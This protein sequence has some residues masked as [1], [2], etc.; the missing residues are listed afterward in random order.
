[1]KLTVLTD[2]TARIDVYC[3]AEPAV[4]YAIEDGDTRVLFDTGYS[5][6]YLRNAR[7]LGLELS[8]VDAAVLSHGHNDHTGGLACFPETDKRPLLYAHPDVFA[9]RRAEGAAIGS[10][11]TREQA[12]ER[13]DLR[14]SR[15]PQRITERLTFLGEIPRRMAFEPPETVGE[16]FL[17]GAW[18]PDTVRDDSALVYRGRDGLCV[19]TGCSHAGICNILA[20]AQ[21]VCGEERIAC[22]VGGFHLLSDSPRVTST[23]DWLARRNIARLCPSHCT[24]FAARAA[25]HRRAPIQEVCVGDVLEIPYT[26]L[27]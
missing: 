16:V 23:A 24:C 26:I 7:T 9:P 27:R 10:P 1:M 18:R 22:V 4:C 5:N 13:F 21:E 20:Y 12:A 19:I 15:A 25:I 6:V 3:L 2:N 14:L 8:R 17:D 11:L